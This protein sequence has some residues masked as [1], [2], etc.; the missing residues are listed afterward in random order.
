MSDLKPS[1]PD[2]TKVPNQQEGDLKTAVRDFWQAAS[3]GEVYAVGSDRREALERHFQER[4]KV[5]P[6]LEKFARFHEAAGLSVLEIGLGMG[7]DHL[8]FAEQAP[9][10]LVG[11]DLTRRAAEWTSDRLRLAGYTPRVL[12]GD[13]ESLPFPDQSFDFVYSWG[14][15]HVTPDTPKAIRE[16]HRLLRKG[17]RARLMLYHYNSIVGYLLWLRYGLFGG[18]PRSGMGNER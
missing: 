17:G 16:V 18:T 5:E 8:R 3:C 12:V 6:Y 2:A 7:A 4:Y 14:V 9:R 11:V 13:A 1:P 15:L 10:S